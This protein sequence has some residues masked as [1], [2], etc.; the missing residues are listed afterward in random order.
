MKGTRVA[1]QSMRILKKTWPP[2]MNW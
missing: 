2:W 1:D